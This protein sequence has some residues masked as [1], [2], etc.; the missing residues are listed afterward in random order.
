VRNSTG[1]P[2]AWP[3][4]IY[5]TAYSGWGEQASVALNGANQ[6]NSGSSGAVALT[7]SIPAN[8]ISTVVVHSTDSTPWQPSYNYLRAAYLGFYS[9][10]LKLPVG[11]S[12]V[13]D[14]DTLSGTI[15]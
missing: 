15:W 7:L 6:W 14:L 13:D 3:L 9:N 11:L 10:C 8:K 1:S 12:Y 2:V 4:N 5:Y